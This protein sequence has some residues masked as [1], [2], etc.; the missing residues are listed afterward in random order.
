MSNDKQPNGKVDF[1]RPLGEFILINSKG[2]IK[3]HS[4]AIP[5]TDSYSQ[6]RQWEDSKNIVIAIGEK[7][8]EVNVGNNVILG[9]HVKMRRAD[10]LTSLVETKLGISL[11]IDFKDKDGKLL[12]MSQDTEKY[13]MVKEE[14]ILAI[15]N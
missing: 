5:N 3:S 6:H 9:P 13:F 1:I 12:G 15:L 4:I 2:K 7:V 8:K 14:D 10:E 11:K